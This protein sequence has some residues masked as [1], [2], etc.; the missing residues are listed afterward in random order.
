MTRILTD[1][2]VDPFATFYV[3]LCVISYFNLVGNPGSM[4]VPPDI[5]MLLYN[6][7]RKFI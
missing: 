1:E 6:Y 7:L 3:N 4:D 5:R 2:V